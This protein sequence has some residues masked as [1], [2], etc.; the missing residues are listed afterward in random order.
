MKTFENP[1]ILVKAFEL[2][3]IMTVSNSDSPDRDMGGMA[4]PWN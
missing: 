3:D 4:T 1:Q 2:E